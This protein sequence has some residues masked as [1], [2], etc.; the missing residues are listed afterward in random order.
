[1]KKHSRKTVKC[2]KNKLARG[3]K[4]RGGS[5]TSKRK[6]KSKTSK[7]NSFKKYRKWSKQMSN[8]P[9]LYFKSKE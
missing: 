2:R 8:R 7:R 1:M 6:S 4:I 3:K 5:E 9:Q